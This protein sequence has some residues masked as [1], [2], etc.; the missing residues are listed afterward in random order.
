MFISRAIVRIT[1]G[2]RRGTRRLPVGGGDERDAVLAPRSG[3]RACRSYGGAQPPGLARYDER[4]NALRAMELRSS[5]AP[6]WISSDAESSIRD[7]GQQRNAATPRQRSR[8]SGNCS[9]TGRR[10]RS[11]KRI[12][13]PRFDTSN[14]TM[15]P[16][17]ICCVIPSTRIWNGSRVKRRSS[18]RTARFAMWNLPAISG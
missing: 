12:R 15:G 1:S 6:W 18:R 13:A 3:S 16:G 14:T 5:L 17:R 8:Q 2:S 10:L 9:T 7:A 11:N 4:P